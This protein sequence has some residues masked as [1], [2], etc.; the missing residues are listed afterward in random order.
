MPSAWFAVSREPT[1]VRKK[2]GH[3]DQVTLL[4]RSFLGHLVRE[5][6]QP[7]DGKESYD[8]AKFPILAIRGRKP[9]FQ[10]VMRPPTEEEL[11]VC[12]YLENPRE[13]PGCRAKLKAP[14]DLTWPAAEDNI[15]EWPGWEYPQPFTFQPEGMPL[16]KE[17]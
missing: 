1:C 9:R 14:A 6:S 7:W 8:S 3:Y 2:N 16:C 17:D 5:I 13:T 4:R 11:K 10:F 15:G 12:E